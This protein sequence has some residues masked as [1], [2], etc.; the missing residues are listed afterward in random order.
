MESKVKSTLGLALLSLKGF[1]FKNRSDDLDSKFFFYFLKC[2]FKALTK[3]AIPTRL[4]QNLHFWSKYHHLIK[5]LFKICNQTRNWEQFFI[6]L[7][8]IRPELYP[9]ELSQQNFTKTCIF[10]QGISYQHRFRYVIKQLQGNIALIFV[11]I[12]LP[13]LPYKVVRSEL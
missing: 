8:L 7:K 13:I 3:W 11:F 9:S 12:N 6:L 2:K 5:K 4:N 1:F 10:G